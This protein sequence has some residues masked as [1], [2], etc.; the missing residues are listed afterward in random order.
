MWCG[1]GKMKGEKG[2]ER[3][4]TEVIV[5]WRSEEVNNL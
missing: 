4:G 5:K 1:I 3:E 2:R